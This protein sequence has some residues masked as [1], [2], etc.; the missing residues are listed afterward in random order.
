M[1]HQL[2]LLTYPAQP[3]HKSPGP[4]QEAAVAMKPSAATLRQNCLDMLCCVNDATADDVASFLRQSV[5]SIRPRFSELLA[6]GLI[7]DTGIRRKN[8][9]GRNATVWRVKA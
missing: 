4:S 1:S 3:G 6:M 5:L 7:E 2:D 8:A 9:S